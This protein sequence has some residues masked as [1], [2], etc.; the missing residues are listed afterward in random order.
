MME[1]DLQSMKETIKESPQVKSASI[2]RV[3]RSLKISIEEHEP[4]MMLAVQ[5]ADEAEQRIVSREGVIYKGLAAQRRSRVCHSFCPTVIRRVLS[6][7]AGN[8]AGSD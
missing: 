8:P 5:G 3:F 7:D 6:A 2:E 1:V 4:V